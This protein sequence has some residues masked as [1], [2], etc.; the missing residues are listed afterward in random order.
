MQRILMSEAKIKVDPDRPATDKNSADTQD[1]WSYSVEQFET[2]IVNG[3]LV[4]SNHSRDDPGEGTDKYIGH[5]VTCYDD[6]I[7]CPT[8]FTNWDQVR[9]LLFY[10]H[11]AG[12]QT[13]GSTVGGSSHTFGARGDISDSGP[14]PNIS[15]CSTQ[16]NTT[17]VIVNIM[18]ESNLGFYPGLPKSS[19][20]MH[21]LLFLWR[22]Y[23]IST[24]FFSVVKRL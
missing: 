7:S 12:R 11:V 13:L 8:L 17:I 2:P 19:M 15:N 6:I 10:A 24:K 3:D 22:C 18:K 20:Y 23:Q 5:V 16:W 4:R 1:H 9:N 14:R 21:A